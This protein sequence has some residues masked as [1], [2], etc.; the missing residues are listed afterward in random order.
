MTPTH[1][2]AV[3]GLIENDRGEVLLV[4]THHRGWEF[5]GGQVEVGETLVDALVR[6]VREE[7]GIEITVLSLVGVY[8]NTATY[9][10]PDGVTEVPSKVMLDF[11]GRAVGGTLGTSDE[12]AASGW[13]PKNEVLSLLSAPAIQTRYRAY[14][15][16]SGTPVYMAYRSRPTF[17]LLLERGI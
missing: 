6:E 3:G 10:G 13:F 4:K 11:T 14:L 15:D 16:G 17:S 1:I 5:P 12:T 8:S 2:V 9:K 7:S